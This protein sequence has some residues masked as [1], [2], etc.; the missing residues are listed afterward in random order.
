MILNNKGFSTGVTISLTDVAPPGVKKAID[1]KLYY[2]LKPIPE[3]WLQA[4]N[5]DQNMHYNATLTDGLGA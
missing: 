2:S 4:A 5:A 3:Y 1:Y